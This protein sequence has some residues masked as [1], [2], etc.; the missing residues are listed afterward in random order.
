MVE[1]SENAIS[2]MGFSDFR[3]RTN[4]TNALLQFNYMQ[5]FR[6]IRCFKD[7]QKI[8]SPYY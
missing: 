2:A 8:I 6:A 4:G 3:I 7:I 1:N 5:Y